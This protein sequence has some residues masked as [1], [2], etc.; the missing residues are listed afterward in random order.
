MEQN[1]NVKVLLEFLIFIKNT[2]KKTQEKEKEAIGCYRKYLTQIDARLAPH[3]KAQLAHDCATLI[4][5]TS[6]KALEIKLTEVKK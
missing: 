5:L 1:F 3:V 2:V 4:L 6:T